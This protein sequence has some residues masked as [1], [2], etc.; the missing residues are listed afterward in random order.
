MAIVMDFEK[1]TTIQYFHI[2]K[3]RSSF[4]CF[5]RRLFQFQVKNC[6]D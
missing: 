5:L 2:L 6:W 1:L 3:M 4:L